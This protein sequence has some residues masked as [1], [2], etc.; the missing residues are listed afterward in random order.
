M[1]ELTYEEKQW[2]KVFARDYEFFRSLISYHEDHGFLTDNQYYY[3]RKQ[4]D[5]EED[6]GDTV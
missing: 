4:I 2:L 6:N 5:D 3:L 1:T